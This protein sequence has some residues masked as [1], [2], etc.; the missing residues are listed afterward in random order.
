MI[1]S[2]P[3]VFTWKDFCSALTHQN[4]A[5]LGS[6]PRGKFYAKIFWLR[7]AN[8]FSCS[9]R[10]CMCHNRL[11]ALRAAAIMSTPLKFCRSYAIVNIF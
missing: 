5:G 3:D 1:F 7:I 8:I 6:L 2:E 11:R 4:M 9:A 10:F